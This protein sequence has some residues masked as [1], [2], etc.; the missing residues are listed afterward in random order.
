MP[1]SFVVAESVRSAS[2][3]KGKR[4]AITRLGGITEFAAR[5]GFEKLGLD[6]KDMTLVQSGSDAQR[7]AAVKS[8]A[9]A[10]TILAPPGLFAATSIGLKVLADLAALGV[11]YPMGVMI[12]SHSYLARNRNTVRKFMMALIEGLDLYL[13]NRNFSIATM[14]KYTRISNSEILS[15]SHDYYVKNTTSIPLT[16]PLAIKNALALDKGAS[17]KSEEFYD[18][19]VIQDLVSEGFVEKVAKSA[20]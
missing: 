2:D 3:L 7:I 5:L 11:K 12:T 10:A 18:N 13:K 15:R 19:S 20:K 4:M 16:E 1:Y 14:Q 6:F 17:R 9:V 8:G